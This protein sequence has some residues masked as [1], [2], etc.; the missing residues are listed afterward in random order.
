VVKKTL[1]DWF[2]TEVTEVTEEGFKRLRPRDCC[3]SKLLDFNVFS[4]QRSASVTSVV[5]KALMV[6]VV[7]FAKSLVFLVF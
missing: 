6:L 1:K 2:T 5:K 7:G 4:V 3:L